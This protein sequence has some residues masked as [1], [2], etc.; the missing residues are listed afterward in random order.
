[1]SDSPYIIELNPDNFQQVVFT[2]SSEVPV[3]VDFWADW[4][5]PCQTLMPLLARLAE[6]YQG[7]F[8]LAKLNTEQHQEIAGQFGIRSL[9]TVKLFK[10]GEPVDEFMGALPE[11]DIRAFLDKHLPRESDNAIAMAQQHLLQGDADT[12]LA[13]LYRTADIDPGNHR[14]TIALAQALAATGKAQEALN[15]LDELN[16]DQQEDPDVKSLR[17][18]LHFEALADQDSNAQLLERLQA[19]PDDH[20]ATLLLA[21]HHVVEQNYP[22]ALDLLLELLKKDRNFADQA[23]QKNMLKIFEILGDDPLVTQYRNQMLN[24]IY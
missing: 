6:E 22:G 23:A 8:I 18:H 14:V 19:N 1:M 7:K 17:G 3:L 20:Q 11:S 15:L 10:A 9:P 5:Q 13:L 4:C 21:A 16:A 12:A 2:G 24:F